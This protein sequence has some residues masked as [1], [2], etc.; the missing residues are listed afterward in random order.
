METYYL[1]RGNGSESLPERNTGTLAQ[2][3]S[4]ERQPTSTSATVG[5]LS[6]LEAI[7]ATAG[8]APTVDLRPSPVEKAVDTSKLRG[9]R[10]QALILLLQGVKIAEIAEKIGISVEKVEKFVKKPE[11]QQCVA[12]ATKKT[13]EKLQRGDFGPIPMAK[14]AAEHS[15]ATLIEL[16]K[17]ARNENVKRQAAIDVLALAGHVA[18]KKAEI[19]N[20]NEL[21]DSM[22]VAELDDFIQHGKWP[23]RLRDRAALLSI[24]K[25]PREIDITPTP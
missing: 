15:M 7:L 22:N 10:A 16:T 14:H 24:T 4:P 11:I 2:P 21:I 20:V 8:S 25:K 1:K 13:L 3:S 5:P 19:L 17:R 9:K 18:V 23:E 12:N 6:P